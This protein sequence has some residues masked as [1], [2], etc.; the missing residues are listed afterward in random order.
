MSVNLINS[1]GRSKRKM[2]DTGIYKPAVLK[3]HLVSETQISTEI[4]HSH[5]NSLSIE[6][7]I[8]V[9][10]AHLP[11]QTSSNSMSNVYNLSHQYN[12]NSYVQPNLEPPMNAMYLNSHAMSA[13]ASHHAKTFSLP[14][15]FDPN[16]PFMHNN[17]MKYHSNNSLQPPARGYNPNGDVPLPNGWSCERASTGQFYYIK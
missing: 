8:N 16:S 11:H 14:V 10:G 13:T 4:Y 17:P 6:N 7:G 2:P 9:V 1:P 5:S 12:P 15:S 3:T